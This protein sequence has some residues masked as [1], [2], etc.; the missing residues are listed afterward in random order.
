MSQKLSDVIEDKYTI[1]EGCNIK[2]Q[3]DGMDLEDWNFAWDGLVSQDCC[4]DCYKTYKTDRYSVIVGG[5]PVN[6]YELT[7]EDA[8]TLSEEWQNNGYQDVCVVDVKTYEV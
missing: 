6:D 5:D 7:L 1:C 4:N 3:V 8:N 2:F